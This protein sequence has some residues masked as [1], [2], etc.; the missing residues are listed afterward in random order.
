MVHTSCRSVQARRTT[1]VVILFFFS[2]RRRHTRCGRD[3]SSDV[4]SSDLF[5]EHE[6]SQ[7]CEGEFETHDIAVAGCHSGREAPYADLVLLGS[8]LL[9]VFEPKNLGRTVLR[10][11]NRSQFWL[12]SYACGPCLTADEFPTR[13]RFREPSRSLAASEVAARLLMLRRRWLLVRADHR[14]A[15]HFVGWRERDLT[16]RR[17]IGNFVVGEQLPRGV[18]GVEYDLHL[19]PQ[20]VEAVPLNRVEHAC[21]HDACVLAGVAHVDG[22]DRAVVREERL[23]RAARLLLEV[24]GEELAVVE[25]RHHAAAAVG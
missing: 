1:I 13:R 9:R 23:L 21:E 2:S 8:R 4:C 17:R 14:A 25:G 7:L 24:D 6:A 19:A 10:A 22:V 5:V 20:R 12:P 11:D 3:W 15:V 16:G 18:A